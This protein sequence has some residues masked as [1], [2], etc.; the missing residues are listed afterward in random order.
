MPVSRRDRAVRGRRGGG[1]LTTRYATPP[2]E[3]QARASCAASA[4]PSPGKMRGGGALASGAGMVV[5][6]V[7]SGEGASRPRVVVA[8]PGPTA[9]ASPAIEVA[10]ARRAA[11]E[12]RV[13]A[14]WAPRHSEPTCGG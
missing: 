1:G 8:A 13:P 11:R 12:T 4:C 10:P 5:E 6:R 14:R 2:M 3:L 9:A 7:R